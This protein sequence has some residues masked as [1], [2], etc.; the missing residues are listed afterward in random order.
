MVS[1]PMPAGVFEEAGRGSNL[2]RQRRFWEGMLT[3]TGEQCE[4]V[5]ECTGTNF[6][7]F[8]FISGET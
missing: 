7:N 4:M 2:W 3:M 5:V 1:V 6:A 8:E